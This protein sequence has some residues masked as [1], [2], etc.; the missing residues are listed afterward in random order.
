MVFNDQLIKIA[1]AITDML[2][3]AVL[4]GWLGRGSRK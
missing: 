3:K 4:F 1:V 2:L